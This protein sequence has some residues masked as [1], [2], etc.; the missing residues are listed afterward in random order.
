METGLWPMRSSADAGD[1]IVASALLPAAEHGLGEG[2][3]GMGPDETDPCVDPLDAARAAPPAS[4]GA[5]A[6]R[7][8]PD[9][10]PLAFDAHGDAALAGVAV[11]SPAGKYV[12][13]RRP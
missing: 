3:I 6:C 8:G 7:L 12:S 2:V 1:R 5:R 11:E 13:R 4:P 10:A 9:P